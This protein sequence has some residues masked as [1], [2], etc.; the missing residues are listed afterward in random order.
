MNV[1]L[2]YSTEQPVD[3]YTNLR[4]SGTYNDGTQDWWLYLC[5]EI[6]TADRVIGAWE[7]R[8]QCAGD[9]YR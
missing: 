8:R 7:P 6:L 4:P 2:A 3:P 1:L 9:G 5:T